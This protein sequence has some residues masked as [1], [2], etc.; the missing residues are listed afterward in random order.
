M[1]VISYSIDKL[2]LEEI[3]GYLVDKFVQSKKR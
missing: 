3:E 1:D 2:D